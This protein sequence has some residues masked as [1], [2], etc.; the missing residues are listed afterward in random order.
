ME[1]TFITTLFRVLI[2]LDN[3][4]ESILYKLVVYKNSMFMA[5]EVLYI[6]IS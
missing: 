4:G 6:M 5:K 1:K 2:V 3:S